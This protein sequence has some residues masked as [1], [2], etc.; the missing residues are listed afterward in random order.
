MFRRIAA[1]SAL[2]AASIASAQTAPATINFE[3][4]TPVSGDWTYAAVA[5][6]SESTFRDTS[7]RSQLWL[8]CTRA[9]R[10]VSIARPGSVAAPSLIVWTSSLTRN[11]P[12][13]FNPVTGRITA[14]LEMMDGLLD[15]MAFSR[16]RIGTSVSGQPPLV[17]PSWEEVARV[18][19]DCRT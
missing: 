16:G 2:V 13:S 17:V 9:T 3:T 10:R 6:G 1:A 7:G 18:V 5:D 4:A 19:E 8:K 11:L 12:A 15:A 14:E